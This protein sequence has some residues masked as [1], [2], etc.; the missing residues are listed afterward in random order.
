MEDEHF[1]TILTRLAHQRG[2]RDWVARRIAQSGTQLFLIGSEPE[3][4][5][6][7]STERYDITVYRDHERGR[8]KA[9]ISLTAA[10]MARLDKR[11]EE[12]AFMAG[13]SGNPPYALPGPEPLP[14]VELSDEAIATPEGA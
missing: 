10:D 1:D 11:L 12:V 13:L 2:V 9:T 14:Q 6:H 7:V 3:A 5:R 8:G 4:L